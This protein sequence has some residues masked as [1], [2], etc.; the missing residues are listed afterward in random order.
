MEE[1]ANNEGSV[2]NSAF[3]YMCDIEESKRREAPPPLL[4]LIVQIFFVDH[5]A[6]P[7]V[8][9]LFSSCAALTDDDFTVA[10]SSGPFSTL[11]VREPTSD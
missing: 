11:P 7:D 6:T 1:L 10:S 4:G 5:K 8:R 9:L 3:A 2:G